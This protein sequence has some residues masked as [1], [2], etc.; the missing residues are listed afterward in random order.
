MPQPIEMTPMTKLDAV[1][2]MLSSI[3]QSPV[4]SLDVPGVRD[5]SIASLQ[6]DNTT[7]EVLTKGW[8]FNSD[9]QYPL[10]PATDGTI[11]VPASALFIDPSDRHLNYVE[12][13]DGTGTM[14]IYDRKNH[15]FIFDRPVKFDIVWGFGFESLPQA[16]RSYIGTRAARL[17]QSNVIG[18]DILFKF[19]E[20]HEREAYATVVRMERRTEDSNV[21]NAPTET[22][23]SIYHRRI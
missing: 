3:G 12:R 22:N 9:T 4:N 8:S 6:I 17:F 10:S 2:V 18:S 19:T 7:R 13:D 1:N 14:K 11:A 20:L 5:I 15:T 16:F 23:M 21:L